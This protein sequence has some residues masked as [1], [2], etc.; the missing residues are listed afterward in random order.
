ML[1]RTSARSIVTWVW[2]WVC[3][4]AATSA[5]PE[6]PSA[7]TCEPLGVSDNRFHWIDYSVVV[8]MLVVSCGIGT[9]YGFFGKKLETSADFLLGGSSMGTIPM[10]MSLA[11]GYIT[12][13][14]LLG[15]PAEMYV[16]GAQFWLTFVSYMIVVP[17]TSYLYLPVFRKVQITSAYEYLEMR[18]NKYARVI[19]AAMYV[20][21]M[22]LYTSVAVYAPALALSHV[23]GLNVY[24]AVSLVYIVCVFY[25]SQ[26][27]MKAVIMADTFQ[28][29]VL[30]ASIVIIVVFGN[31]LVGGFSKIFQ[32]N[33]ESNRIELMV[34]DPDP[35]VRHSVWSVVIGGT[36]YWATMYCANQASIQK[37]MTVETLD[38]ARRALWVSSISLAVILSINFYTGM[39]M[40]AEYSG[41][42]P[43]SSGVI[44]ASDQLLP[45]YV[46]SSLG[47][48]RGVPGLFVA[49]IFAASLGTVA[50]ALNSLAAVTIKDFFGCLFGFKIP[51]NKGSLYSKWISVFY[52]ILSFALVF[53]VEHLG[54]VLQ[55]ALSFNGMVGGVTLGMFSLG[56]FIPWANS[57]GVLTGATVAIC[58]V[59]WISFGAQLAIANGFQTADPKLVSVAECACNL[60]DQI[61]EADIH[62]V[63]EIYK[64]SYLWYS[65]IGFCVTIV[66]GFVTSLLTGVEDPCRVHPDLISPPIAHLLRNLP[67]SIKEKLSLPIESKSERKSQDLKKCQKP[68]MKGIDNPAITLESELPAPV[69]PAIIR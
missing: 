47:S 60:T 61:Y 59:L 62:E 12:A 69:N 66:V 55:V 35:R 67:H 9:F 15:N 5:S 13:I 51:D 2:L 56:M 57:K 54:S 20:F 46:M 36:F 24:I 48:Y 26:G 43:I 21:Q 30:V 17:I 53:V 16:Y 6:H 65:V 58:L 50:S 28:A 22:I 19:A 63:P 64:I 44:S 10:A 39:I 33:V 45:L 38:Q 25:A 23:T 27:G 49:G 42:D 32:Q 40:Y 41:C 3:Q 7:T 18:F 52:G 8:A 37:Y 68:E 34:M 4:L 31:N 29:V 11:A 1:S 14:E